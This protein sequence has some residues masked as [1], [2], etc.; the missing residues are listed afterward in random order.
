MRMLRPWHGVRRGFSAAASP[1]TR[2]LCS[3]EALKQREGNALKFALASA[4]EEHDTTSK[5]RREA[6]T[7]FVFYCEAT[8]APR[9]FVNQCP[10]ALLEL[11]LDDSDF[12]CEG[13]IQCKAH[14]AFF[15]PRTGICLQGPAA[16]R[17]GSRTQQLGALP[18][19]SV[20]VQDG[21]V[22]LQEATITA[23]RPRRTESDP[24]TDELL[25]YRTQRQK[26]LAK[27]L[28][29]RV[30]DVQQI[31]EMLNRKA[32]ERMQRFASSSSFV[33]KPRN[34]STDEK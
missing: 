33:K 6:L 31:Q 8:Q 10:H 28:A 17:R 23:R 34:N 16:T 11:D 24:E 13:F 29:S 9:A 3:L 2:V 5:R 25:E 7:G 15:D 14:G 22:V 12:F 21:Q 20:T 18:E 4:S 26:E 32:M 30:N 19:L 27:A 1:T